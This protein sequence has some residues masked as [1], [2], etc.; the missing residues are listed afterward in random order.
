MINFDEIAQGWCDHTSGN[1]L[2]SL[3]EDFAN[4]FVQAGMPKKNA[5]LLVQFVCAW[6]GVRGNNFQ[7]F[8]NSVR[9]PG[10]GDEWL[11][12]ILL[13]AKQ[14]SIA[15]D[16]VGAI[17][18]FEETEGLG[19]SF[20]SKVLRFLCPNYAAVLDSIIREAFGYS[21]SRFGYF[22][23]VNDC[24][25]IRDALNGKKLLPDG[26]EAWRTTD[27]EMGLFIVARPIARERA[28]KKKEEKAK[29]KAK[30]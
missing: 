10:R 22:D 3:V 27:V 2:T 13:K 6:G 15:K 17:C 5:F 23:F 24:V 25:L 18:A 9:Q 28:T 12:S 29:A 20:R 19:V 4:K 1:P 30:I 11:R 7:L 8:T 21:N 14:A 16:Y 26:L